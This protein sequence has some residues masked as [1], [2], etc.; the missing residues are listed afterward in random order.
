M[1]INN[2]HYKTLWMNGKTISLID[3]NKIPFSFEIIETNSYLDTC[4]EIKDMTVRGA[5]AIGVCAGYA[6][7]Q[8]ALEAPKETYLTF[9][10]QAKKDIEATRPTARNLFY[11]TERVFEAACISPTKAVEMAEKLAFEDESACKK[12]GEYGNALIKDGMNIETHCNAGWLAFVDFGSALSPIYE[13]VRTGKNIHVWVDETAPRNQGAKLTAWELCNENISNTII[14]DNAGALL[15]MNGKVD[16]MIVGADRIAAN[17]DTANKIGTLEKAIIA[18]EFGIPFY[19][20][21]PIATI[22]ISCNSGVEIPIEER[23]QD[24]VLYAYGIA[25]ESNS[26]VKVRTSAPQAKA[27]NPGF[28]VTLAKYITGIITEKG[29]IKPNTEAIQSLFQINS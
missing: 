18:K 27:F 25:E 17:G 7:A 13:A 3:Q 22:D 11:S 9:I 14:P 4:K 28:D 16:M 12:I 19:I 2:K 8:A 5:G 10:S 15:M 20:A 1:H 26:I 21:A 6:M 23:H 29:I 24:E